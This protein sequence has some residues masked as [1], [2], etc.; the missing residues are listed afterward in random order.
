MSVMPMC[1]LNHE[2]ALPQKKKQ[3]EMVF[4]EFAQRLL[5]P[6][7]ASKLARG[8]FERARISTAMFL[9]GTRTLAGGTPT[10]PGNGRSALETHAA[11][12]RSGLEG[13]FVV[14]PNGFIVS[15]GEAFRN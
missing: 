12:R 9:R 13:L 10:L 14:S 6:F 3:E 4:H 11:P 5:S 2:E 8:C 15:C 1:P 7:L